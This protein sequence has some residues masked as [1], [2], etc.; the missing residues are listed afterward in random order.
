MVTMFANMNLYH[1]KT[2]LDKI[3]P[4]FSIFASIL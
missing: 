2:I 4:P 3:I 1:Q